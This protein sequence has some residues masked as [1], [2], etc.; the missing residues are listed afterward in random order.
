LSRL[1]QPGPQ[2]QHGHSR[3][4]MHVVY[5]LVNFGGAGRFQPFRQIFRVNR[6]LVGDNDVNVFWVF[7]ELSG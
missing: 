3:M 1:P 7:S 5:K 6:F 4:Q 2:I